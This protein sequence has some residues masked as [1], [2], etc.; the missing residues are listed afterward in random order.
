MDKMTDIARDYL[1]DFEVL[2]EARKELEEQLDKWWRVLLPRYVQPELQKLNLGAATEDWDN[3]ASPGQ[4]QF[5]VIKDQAI[6]LQ[7][8]DP[9][10]SQRGC[11]T[12]TLLAKSQP[13]LKSM[14]K[15]EEIVNRLNA[16][17][18]TFRVGDDS[19]LNWIKTELAGTDIQIQPDAPE[20]TLKQVCDAV[21]QCFRLIIEHHRLSS[22]LSDAAK[23]AAT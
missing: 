7:L 22:E 4:C 16:L 8:T 12:V 2:T 9:R 23:P 19:G 5:R 11:Y 18:K 3:K 15:N 14:S 10:F 20:V 6:F 17:A 21:A 13:A 1:A